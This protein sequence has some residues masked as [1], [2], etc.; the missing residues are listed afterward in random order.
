M[1]NSNK[2]LYKTKQNKK[3]KIQLY[4]AFFSVDILVMYLYIIY[5]I[6]S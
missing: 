4:L 3:S 5:T 1:K 2:K 6:D